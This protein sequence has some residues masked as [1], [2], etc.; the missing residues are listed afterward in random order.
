MSIGKK[1]RLSRIRDVGPLLVPWPDMLLLIC[2]R[3][4]HSREAAESH[5][6]PTFTAD[7]VIQPNNV[8]NRVLF[9]TLGTTRISSERDSRKRDEVNVK[10][11]IGSVVAHS[12][13]YGVPK[14]M[15]KVLGEGGG[16]GMRGVR[17]AGCVREATDFQST[18]EKKRC[19]LSSS[20]VGRLD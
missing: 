16:A 15:R 18:E 14:L 2:H 9:A 12:A 10:C 20:I 7:V 19:A 4:R 5:H 11:G 3:Q 13:L 8:A 1:S 17:G 6:I